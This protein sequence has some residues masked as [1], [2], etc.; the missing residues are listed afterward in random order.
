MQKIFKGACEYCSGLE[1][2]NWRLQNI[3]ACAQETNQFSVESK[4]YEPYLF[5]FQIFVEVLAEEIFFKG[6]IKFYP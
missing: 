6:A 2:L 1:D 5:D 4:F 3:I